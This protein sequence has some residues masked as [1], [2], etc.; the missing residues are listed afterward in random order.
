[1]FLSIPPSPSPSPSPSLPPS[2]PCGFFFRE[3][4]ADSLDRLSL[5]L[6]PEAAAIFCHE[7]PKRKLVAPHCE[8]PQEQQTPYTYLIVD[9]GG[10]TVDISRYA[11]QEDPFIEMVHPLVGN[12]CGGLRVNNAFK[13]FFKRLVSDIKF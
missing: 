12:D 1:M 5:A 11:L 7:M 3:K 9:I 8:T 2:L 10:G 4:C 13:T 6:E